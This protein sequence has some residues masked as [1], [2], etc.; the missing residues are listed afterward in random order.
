MND[1][2]CSSLVIIPSR[3]RCCCCCCCCNR[4]WRKPGAPLLLLHTQEW[5]LAT[6]F[7]SRYS[8][9]EWVRRSKHWPPRAVEALT[10]F[11]K[12]QR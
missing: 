2:A 6:E 3:C 11:L 9:L 4:C 8:D 12:L 1:P 7:D 10:R 5:S